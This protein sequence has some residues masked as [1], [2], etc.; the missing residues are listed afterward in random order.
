MK[1]THWGALNDALNADLRMKA[2]MEALEERRK[3]LR[4]DIIAYLKKHKLSS[5][6]VEGNR[7]SYAPYSVTRFDAKRFEEEH[8]R[9]YDKYVKADWFT[10]LTIT[11]KKASKAKADAKK[12]PKPEA[13]NPATP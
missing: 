5:V 3:A 13:A 9:L 6:T 11:P 12:S 8:K 4:E 10:R 2:E 1:I 7:V